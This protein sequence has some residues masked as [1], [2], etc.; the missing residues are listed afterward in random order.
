MEARKKSFRYI[1]F[2]MATR[3]SSG[4]VRWALRYPGL[5]YRG[6]V[7]TGSLIWDDIT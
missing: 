3:N 1:K 5:E 6:E 2:E 4:E 7:E